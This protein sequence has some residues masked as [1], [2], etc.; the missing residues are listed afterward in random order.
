MNK[1]KGFIAGALTI[2]GIVGLA[3]A[4]SPPLEQMVYE[5][6]KSINN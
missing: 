4:L 2:V 1:L 6:T 5:Y 3:L